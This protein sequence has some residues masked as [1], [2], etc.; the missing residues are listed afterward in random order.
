MLAFGSSTLPV[1]FLVGFVEVG[2]I[3]VETQRG[4]KLPERASDNPQPL[5]G[6]VLGAPEDAV[7]VVTLG[8]AYLSRNRLVTQR[9]ASM[10]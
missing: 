2:G 3:D 9:S 8:Q 4:K 6:E 7:F 10:A 5:F 1:Q